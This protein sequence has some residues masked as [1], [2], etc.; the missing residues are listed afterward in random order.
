MI[1]K[2]FDN[3]KVFLAKTIFLNNRLSVYRKYILAAKEAGYKVCSLKEFWDDRFSK[4]KHFVLRHDVD[5]LL[6]A[7]RKM[8][9]VEKKLGV[10]AT[11]YFRWSTIDKKLIKDMLD[12]GFEVGLHYET[13]ATYISEHNIK[14]KEDLPLKEMQDILKEE[15]KKFRNEFSPDMVSCCSHGAQENRDLDVSSNILLEDADYSEF[16]IQ[17]EAYDKDMYERCNIYHIMDCNLRFSFG[18][19]YKANPIDGII[20]DKQNI[21]FLS[22]P[23]HWKLTFLSWI[24]DCIRFVLGK[25]TYS[26]ERE[27]RRIAK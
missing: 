18:F 6:P 24:G 5:Q 25:N 21:I 19:A 3:S 16:G 20:E 12:A 15:I 9:E 1:T 10:H 4:D 22:H 27:F 23:I 7:T 26:T 8:F 14:S 17:F 11:Y 2:R 13:V